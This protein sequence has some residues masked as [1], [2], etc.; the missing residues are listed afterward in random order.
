MTDSTETLLPI[1]SCLCYK[2]TPTST[3][4][5]IMAAKAFDFHVES[6]L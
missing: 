6:P 2:S 4:T 3:Y 1:P 5:Q